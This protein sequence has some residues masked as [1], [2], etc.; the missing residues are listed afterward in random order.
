[1]NVEA[2]ARGDVDGDGR[3]DSADLLQQTRTG[4]LDTRRFGLRVRLATRRAL[5]YWYRWGYAENEGQ[6]LAGIADVDGDGRGDVVLS[7]GA[8]AIARSWVVW[9]LLGGRLVALRG[10]DLVAGVYESW[11][12]TR[13]PQRRVWVATSEPKGE[14][15]ATGRVTYYRVSGTTLV[16]TARGPEQTW[17]VGGRAPAIFERGI[18]CGGLGSAP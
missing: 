17:R 10:A 12:C 2:T 15:D 5:T 13:D 7:P 11:G 9:R 3:T 1:M 8:S 18:D 16:R 6:E 4:D 14:R